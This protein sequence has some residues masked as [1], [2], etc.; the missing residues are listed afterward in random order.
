MLN[1]ELVRFIFVGG[2]ATI[3]HLVAA[4]VGLRLA[5]DL[6]VVFINTLAF[7]IAF[8]V[9]YI[10]HRYF[11]F[12]REGRVLKFFLVAIVGLLINNSIVFLVSL[13]V[14]FPFLAIVMGTSVSP[15]MVFLLSKYWAFEVK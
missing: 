1:F 15:I 11:T 12:N 5:P 3:T 7:C 8:V 14:N 6:N 9:S 13:L 2:A 4:A 10:G